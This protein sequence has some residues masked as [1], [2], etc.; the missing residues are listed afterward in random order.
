MTQSLGVLHQ[1]LDGDSLIKDHTYYSQ[2]GGLIC[3]SVL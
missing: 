2:S 3:G 1:V